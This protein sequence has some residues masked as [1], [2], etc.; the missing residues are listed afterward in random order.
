M[1]ITI[2]TLQQKVFQID[3]DAEDTVATLKG[4]ISEA[5]GH[6]V[7]SQK[8]IYSGRVLLDSKTVAECDIK[9]KDFLVLMVAKPKP[10]FAPAPS[11]SAVPADV[12]P[13]AQ[14]AVPAAP[15]VAPAPSAPNP[16]SAPAPAPAAASTTQT[17]GSG[18][19]SFLSGDVLQSTI[20]N[21]MEMG[22]ERDAVVRALRASFNNP[23]RAVEYLFNGIPEHLLAQPAAQEPAPLPTAAPAPAP[24]PAQNQPQGQPQNLFQLAQ[25]RQQQ[26]V[27]GPG[28]GGN[29]GARDVR[30]LSALAGNPEV[31][32]L[33]ELV[34]QNPALLQPLVQQLAAANPQ[35]AQ[36]LAENP[37]AALDY[38]SNAGGEDD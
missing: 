23:E 27:G 19:A 7:E 3:A 1:K 8:L 13:P 25:Q 9:E 4:K 30:N 20:Q 29:V 33:R 32:Q 12:P 14:S 15:E 35:L 36:I 11:V 5:H 10:N 17:T 22:F 18:P 21:M 34:Q 28:A 6:P 24:V 31:A 38:L 2:K 26:G 16:P 37:Q